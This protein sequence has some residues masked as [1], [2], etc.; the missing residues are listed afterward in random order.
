MPTPLDYASFRNHYLDTGEWTAGEQ[1][2][3]DILDQDGGNAATW[4]QLGVAVAHL[5]R[6]VEADEAFA[7]ALK[8]DPRSA[9]SHYWRGK[10]ADEA[11][12]FAA[13]AA[14]YKAALAEEPD[15]EPAQ[16]AARFNAVAQREVA[17]GRERSDDEPA[18]RPR[19][20][21][22]KA[23][24]TG[25][26]SEIMH[27]LGALL[28]AEITGRTPVVLWGSNSMFRDP[29]TIDG[30]THYF[31]PVSA[32]GLGDLP[33]VVGDI[34]PPKWTPANI[35]S[36]DL[37]QQTGAFSR[38]SGAHFVGRPERLVV[39]DYFT[40]THLARHWIPAGHPLHG[41]STAEVDRWLARKYLR[42]RSYLADRAA[43]F[44]RERFSGVPFTAVQLR[45]TDKSTEM[46]LLD[47]LNRN[48]I[49][50]VA[51]DDRVFVLTDSIHWQAA[52]VERLGDRAHFMPVTRGAG[53]TGIHFE[54][55]VGPRRLGEEVLTDVLVAT[56]AARFVGN[57]WSS[58]SCGVRA[59]SDAPP[60][61][62]QLLGPFDM[63]RD[64]YGE[65]Y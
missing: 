53:E 25:F 46:P 38:L 35:A 55:S 12:A 57:G 51:G 58:V 59:L 47:A 19:F 2:C 60:E 62:L 5:A 15:F 23:W 43:A 32:A 8:L 40:S 31:E 13:A 11:G 27:L 1:H 52:A 41:R 50:R 63:G 54:R 33:V 26:W 44:A 9:R 61:A 36:D 3:R 22:I 7:S 64:H 18:G 6:K 34:F 45:G 48:A 28:T 16:Y 20:L 17:L 29:G 21:L 4:Q 42:P 39:I 56:R 37:D 49:D 10:M 65:Y 14:H 24:G 30:Y